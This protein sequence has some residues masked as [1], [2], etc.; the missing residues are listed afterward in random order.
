MATYSLL[1]IA[2][3]SFLPLRG[4]SRLSLGVLSGRFLRRGVGLAGLA[5]CLLAVLSLLTSHGECGGEGKSRG[6]M[7]INVST[8][9]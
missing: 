9:C 5:G 8:Y 2:L 6:D 7:Q 3:R 4:L 1:G